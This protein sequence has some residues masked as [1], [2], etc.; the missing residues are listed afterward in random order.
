MTMRNSTNPSQISPFP[1]LPT[2]LSIISPVSEAGTTS[3]RLVEA[4]R[5]RKLI[6]DKIDADYDEVVRERDE[7]IA[8]NA[9]SIMRGENPAGVSGSR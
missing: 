5:K 1:V 2:P 4:N 3:L 7:E 9:A 8:L 6:L